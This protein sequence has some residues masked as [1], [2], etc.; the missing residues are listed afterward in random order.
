LKEVLRYKGGSFDEVF[1]LVLDFLDE[2]EGYKDSDGRIEPQAA[3]YEEEKEMASSPECYKEETIDN[4]NDE[5]TNEVIMVLYFN[6]R[7]QYSD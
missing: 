2:N 6:F 3:E 7:E 1:Q 5:L 4:S